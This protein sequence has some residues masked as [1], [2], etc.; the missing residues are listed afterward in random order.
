M[1]A[2]CLSGSSCDSTFLL[3][4][5]NPKQRVFQCLSLLCAGLRIQLIPHQVGPQ[6]SFE[7]YRILTD[8]VRYRMV[9]TEALKLGAIPAA[10]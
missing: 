2:Y 7:V 1:T 3:S 8:L 4:K 6:Y 5:H 9:T 10:H